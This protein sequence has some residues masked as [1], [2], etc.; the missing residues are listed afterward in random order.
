MW[1]VRRLAAVKAKN[2]QAISAEDLQG[3]YRQAYER[4]CIELKE[5]QCELRTRYM[6]AVRELSEVMS[7]SVYAEAGK[8]IEWLHEEVV[9]RAEEHDGDALIKTL[10][11]AF[12]VFFT[13]E[14][15][16]NDEQIT[17]TQRGKE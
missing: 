16:N 14:V 13:E 11:Y 7:E 2:E 9:R 6:D 1:E 12:C 10:F 4:L 5:R 8:E 3:K 15:K 17:E